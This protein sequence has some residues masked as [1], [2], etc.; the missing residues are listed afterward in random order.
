MAYYTVLQSN[1]TSIILKNYIFV[2]KGAFHLT[3]TLFSRFHKFQ[4]VN[5]KPLY[6]SIQAKI[7][8]K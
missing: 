1:P 7:R 5:N 3:L 8:H 6:L 4:F 2:A